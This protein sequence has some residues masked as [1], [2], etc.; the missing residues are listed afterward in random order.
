MWQGPRVKG[1]R[2]WSIGHRHF[3]ARLSL[4]C[5]QGAG[6]G[7]MEESLSVWEQGESLK[8]RHRVRPA[9]HPRLPLPAGS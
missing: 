8:A 5:H 6:L 2:A 4:D 3:G 9:S 1:Q 7:C